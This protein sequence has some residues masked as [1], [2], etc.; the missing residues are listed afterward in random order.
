MAIIQGQIYLHPLLFELS[1]N[2]SENIGASFIIFEQGNSPE[3]TDSFVSMTKN[4]A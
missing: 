1:I 3:V 2:S 4:Q